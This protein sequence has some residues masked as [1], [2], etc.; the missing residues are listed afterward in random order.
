MA[1][2]IAALSFG[3]LFLVLYAATLIWLPLA[4]LAGGVALL[5]LAWVLDE[6]SNP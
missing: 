2:L 6:R 3:G 1:W 5:R 4:W